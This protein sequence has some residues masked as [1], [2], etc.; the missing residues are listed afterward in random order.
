MSRSPPTPSSQANVLNKAISS[1]SAAICLQPD[2][3]AKSPNLSPALPMTPPPHTH[4]MPTPLRASCLAH[5]D[6]Q[7]VVLATTLLEKP[8]FQDN[9]LPPLLPLPTPDFQLPGYSLSAAFADFYLPGLS[10]LLIPCTLGFVASSSLKPQPYVSSLDVFLIISSRTAKGHHCPLTKPVPQ[11][12]LPP[13][14]API[15][16]CPHPL[17]TLWLF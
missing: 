12:D 8:C 9:P 11:S 14:P 4:N 17:P 2:A 7:F 5:A 15:S 10:P 6:K 13:I 16:S 1:E 3:A